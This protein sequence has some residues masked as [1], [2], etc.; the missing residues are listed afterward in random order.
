MD[1]SLT[2]P[3]PEGGIEQRSQKGIESPVASFALGGATV[4]GLSSFI[5]STGS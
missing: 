5:A 1:R 4:C 2:P 3:R